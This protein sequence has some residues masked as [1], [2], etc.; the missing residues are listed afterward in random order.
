MQQ[1]RERK[2]TLEEEI[3]TILRNGYDDSFIFKNKEIIEMIDD[4]LERLKED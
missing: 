1:L 4:I 2:N 3:Q